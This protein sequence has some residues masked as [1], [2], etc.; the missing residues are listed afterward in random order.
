MITFIKKVFQK[1]ELR[2]KIL[3]TLGMLFVFR[4]GSA[5]TIPAIDGSKLSPDLGG[6][7]ILA[8]MN[9]LGGGSLERFSLF[10]LGVSP[11]ITSSIII[12]LLSMD[13]IPT[14]TQ[15]K[16]EGEVGRK[17]KDKVTRYVTVLL[18]AIQGFSLTYAFDNGY[19]ILK[20]SSV[21]SYAYVVI[22]MVAGAMFAM[23][24]G[25]QM[26]NKGIGNGISLLIFTGIV[27]NLPASFISAFQSL[28]S[29]DKGTQTMLVG[30]LSYTGFVLFYLLI[31]VFVIFTEGANRKIKTVYTSNSNPM[32]RTRDSSYIPI[33]INSAG[34]IPVIFASSILATPL[35]ISQLIGN[36]TAKEII[37]KICT[38]NMP[39]VYPI[40]FVLYLILIVLF[41]FFYANM[42]IDVNKIN[43]DLASNGGMVPG[44]N[45]WKRDKVKEPEKKPS[46]TEIYLYKV[47]NRLTVI[48]AIFLVIIAVIPILIPVIWDSVSASAVTLYGTGLII[49]TGVAL[50]T[51]DQMK[52][53]ITRKEYKGR[54]RR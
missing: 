24:M 17:K 41:S 52:T 8:L 28:V 2:Q 9:M 47:L 15:W 46:P 23:W 38:Y 18:A 36:S 26:T 51:V 53:Y 32:M 16:E 20:E 25:D 19:G 13:V 42:Q 35:T 45:I 14:L 5:I 33:K 6:T 11:Y 10:S 12:E 3:F 48:G 34:V 29:F 27:S 30:L 39:G 22:V 44:F 37:E 49:A 43:N 4:I 54:I 50:E 7:G 1:G 21:L 40:G 31:L